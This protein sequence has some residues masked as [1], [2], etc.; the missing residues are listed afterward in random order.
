MQIDWWTLG[1]QAINVLILV[2]LLQRFLLKPVAAIIEARR[3]EAASVISQAEQAR[4]DAEAERQKATEE[5][6][7]ITESRGEALKAAAAEAEVA[8]AKLL[9]QARD[10][11]ETLRRAADAEI[12]R[13]RR[14]AAAADAEHAK[15]L[16][17]EIAR[18]LFTR[19]PDEAKVSG[20]IDGLVDVIVALPEESRSDIGKGTPLTLKTARPLTAGEDE[21]LHTRLSSALGRPVDLTVVCDTD[22]IAGLEIDTPHA[23][24]RNSFRGDL[25]RIA[26]GLAHE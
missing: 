3:A 10:E 9:A 22:L 4:A 15:A 23:L 25:D 2:W 24:V 20:F 11:A 12:D 21:T 19:L 14:E 26:R 1:L 7:R 13:K 16:A 17:V 8:K 6:Q 18:K 5:V